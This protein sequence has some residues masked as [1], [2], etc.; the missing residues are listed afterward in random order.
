MHLDKGFVY[1][2]SWGGAICSIILFILIGAYAVQKFD[3]LVRIQDVDLMI[4]T[5]L[6]ALSDHD[7]FDSS[8]GFNIAAG[9]MAYQGANKPIDDDPTVGELVFVVN[10]WGRKDDG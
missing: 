2:R 3:V 7:K 10:I 8:M 5:N 6:N 4:T 1:L 9:F